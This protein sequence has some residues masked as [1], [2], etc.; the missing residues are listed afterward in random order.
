[1]ASLMAHT[2][3]QMPAEDGERFLEEAGTGQ[4]SKSTSDRIPQDL[5]AVL[6]RDRAELEEVLSNRHALLMRESTARDSAPVLAA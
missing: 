5:S 4:V 3:A 6:E 2:V 1:M